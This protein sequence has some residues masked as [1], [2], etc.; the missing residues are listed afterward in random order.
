MNVQEQVEEVYFSRRFAALLHIDDVEQLQVM[1][2]VG[3]SGDR[4]D[5]SLDTTD[6]IRLNNYSQRLSRLRLTPSISAQDG[7]YLPTLNLKPEG[8]FSNG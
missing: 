4:L 2:A 8:F 7:R 1:K 3:V 5:V 6:E